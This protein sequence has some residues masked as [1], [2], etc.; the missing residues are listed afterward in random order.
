MIYRIWR[1]ETSDMKPR[2][3]V[4]TKKKCLLYYTAHSLSHESSAHTHFRCHRQK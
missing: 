4:S 2:L 3:D 1:Y